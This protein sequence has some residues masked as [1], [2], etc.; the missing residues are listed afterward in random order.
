[1]KT[2][3]KGLNEITTL[4]GALLFL[5]MVFVCFFQ[6]VARYFF[7]NAAD[8]PEEAS[9]FMFIWL[10]YLGMSYGFFTNAH[11]KVDL[12]Y[13]LFSKRFHKYIDVFGNAV[14]VIFLGV[15]A[16]QG[17]Q[18]IDI[19]IESEEEAM[20]LPIP[21]SIVWLSIPFSFMIASVN[22]FYVAFIRLIDKE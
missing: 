12:I 18:M 19:V 5:I 10:A 17:L 1:M 4:F 11:L 14:S 6:V 2:I 15:V 20:T 22:C 21:L 16:W 13:S 7:N 3:I 8:W 9:R